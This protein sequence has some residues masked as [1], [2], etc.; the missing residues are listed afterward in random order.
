MER[1]KDVKGGMVGAERVCVEGEGKA[2][3]L[4]ERDRQARQASS[5]VVNCRKG[6]AGQ[7][8][9]RKRVESTKGAF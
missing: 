1:G 3:Q 8:E 2:G 4:E 9:G 5:K 6:R 7:T